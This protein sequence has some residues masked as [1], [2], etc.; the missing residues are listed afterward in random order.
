MGQVLPQNSYHQPDVP[1]TAY[2]RLKLEA[3]T[4]YRSLKK[5]EALVCGPN[6]SAL[7]KSKPPTGKVVDGT[8]S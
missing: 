4:A 3:P 7:T 5:T 2:F 6:D 1:I 8:Y